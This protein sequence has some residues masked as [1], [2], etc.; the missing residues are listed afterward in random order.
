M[1]PVKGSVLL[2][3]C[4]FTLCTRGGLHGRQPVLPVPCSLFHES[5]FALHSDSTHGGGW[6]LYRPTVILFSPPPPLPPLSSPA[7]LAGSGPGVLL[8]QFS[9]HGPC[10]LDQGTRRLEHWPAGCEVPGLTGTPLSPAV[11]DLPNLCSLPIP[12]FTACPSPRKVRCKQR[13]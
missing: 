7:H 10:S 6:H 4:R 11:L 3:G 8:A 1:S 13:S 12:G 2:L 5:L 9:T